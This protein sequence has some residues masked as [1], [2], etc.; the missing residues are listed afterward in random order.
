MSDMNAKINWLAEFKNEETEKSF[1]ESDRPTFIKH[2]KMLLVIAGVLYMLFIIPD[3]LLISD[4][5][6]FSLILANRLAVVVMVALLYKKIG[7]IRRSGVI[8][9]LV[10]LCEIIIAVSFCA[11]FYQYENPDFLIQTFGLMIIIIVIYLAPNRW[12]LKNVA[13][14][15]S[16]LAFFGITIVFM[17]GIPFAKFSAG[18]VYTLLVMF[19][20]SLSSFNINHFKRIAYFNNKRLEYLSNT[21]PLTGTFNRKKF[22]AEMERYLASG[23]KQPEQAALIMFDIDDFKEIND[24]HGH[25]MG[26]RVITELAGIVKANIRGKDM[27]FR[28][29][30]EEFIILIENGDNKRAVV[31]AEKLRKIIGEHLFQGFLRVTCSFGVVADRSAYSVD[32][33]LAKGDKFLYMAKSDGKNNV[34]GRENLS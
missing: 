20:S 4:P 25:L 29:G 11:V 5:T 14:I 30:G 7:D 17:K 23:D 16:Y 10:T 21:D 24:R 1:F 33:I 6:V 26:D 13:A 32:E 31:V 8:Y 12:I 34:K 28:W 27:L 15:V 2:I 22:N 9:W 3:S 18:L 19:F